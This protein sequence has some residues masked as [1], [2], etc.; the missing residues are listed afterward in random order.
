[1]QLTNDVKFILNRLQEYG[2]GLV[3]GG[4]VRDYLLGVEP[5]DYDFATNIPY[6]K[7]LEIFK[8]YNPKEI[9]KSFGIIQ[10]NINEVNYEIALYRTDGNYSDNRKPDS[11]KFV[12]NF[13]EDSSRRDISIN[14]IGYD[15]K[16]FIDYHEGINDLNN[17]LICCVR[18]A[19]NR[20][21]EDAL[22]M[23][24][25]IRFATKYNFTIEQNTYKA[26]ENCSHLIQNISAERIQSELNK[27][28]L[29]DKPST[30]IRLLFNTGLL[31]YILPELTD[32]ADFEQNNPNHDKDVFEHTMSVLDNTKPIL[33]N[34][35]S[36]LFHDIGKPQTFSL[37]ENGVGH[38]YGHDK[39]SEEMSHDIMKRLKYTLS[40]T[41]VVM[42]LVGNHMNK[43]QKQSNKSIKKLINRIT[44]EYMDNYFDLLKADILGSIAPYNFEKLNSLIERVGNIKTN[45]EPI[46]KRDLEI[47]GNDIIS[48]TGIK[49]GKKVGEL[50]N[51]IEEMVLIDSKLNN[52]E[53]LIEI[54]KELSKH[55]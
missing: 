36:A 37:D 4:C 28:L 53:T 8:D 35:L 51:K 38:F 25:A 20:F 7:L 46:C 2:D 22:R 19:E 33:I 6:D 3:V 52:K 21:K 12:S 16:I 9:G 1:M 40:Q 17:K 42:R 45:N 47:S 14:A 31:K 50:L 29:C 41:D 23:L 27:I 5:K 34:R 43:S 44:Y 54:A 55:D 39:K 26:I 11:V 15:G 32:C 48:I 10:I 13:Y 24:R 18:N 49:Q 30:G